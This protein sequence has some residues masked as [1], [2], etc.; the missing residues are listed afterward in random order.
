MEINT[1]V[2][3]HVDELGR[4][5]FEA[6]KELAHRHNFSLVY[7]DLASAQSLVDSTVDL[8]FAYP[9]AAFHDGA[10]VGYSCMWLGSE[11]SGIG[12]VGVDPLAQG[13][14]A[15]KAMISHF[16]D[17][18]EQQGIEMIRLTQ[19]AYN[20]VSLSLYASLGFDVRESFM[21]LTALPS[22]D[23]EGAVREF[24][25]SDYPAIK[26]LSTRLY[27]VDRSAELSELFDLGC[28]A[29]VRDRSGS[30]TGYIVSGMGG[31]GMAETDD[32]AL[33]LMGESVL[34]FPENN[35][36]NCPLS[37][38]DFYRKAL[39]VGC[40]AVEVHT[41]MTYGRYERP[42]GIWMPSSNY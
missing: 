30:I 42:D 13:Q 34:R 20:P 1:A 17:Y 37:L 28:K 35:E 32:D 19:H 18:C 24:K 10:P 5:L 7:S 9:I 14:G 21:E 12:P 38:G 41:L 22:E 33:A 26:E 8:D 36:F 27:K 29:I 39:K 3:D 15:A 11:V 2:H 23:P 25:E 31:H 16:I 6:F 4:I 40:R